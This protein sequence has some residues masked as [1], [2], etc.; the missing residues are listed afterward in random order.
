MVRVKDGHDLAPE[1]VVDACRGE[2]ASFKLPKYVEFIEDFPYTSTGKIQKQRL[3]DRE[4][5]QTLTITCATTSE[6]RVATVNEKR[7]R[8]CRDSEVI[9]EVLPRQWKR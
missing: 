5:E 3:R 7:I 9:P 8:A 2:L 6:Q 4:A 1:D